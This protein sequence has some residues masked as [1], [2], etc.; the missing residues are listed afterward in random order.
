MR[1]AHVAVLVERLGDA[2]IGSLERDVV[3]L[4]ELKYSK[5]TS[6]PVRVVVAVA[7]DYDV[8][9]IHQVSEIMYSGKFA[10]GDIDLARRFMKAFLRGVRYH[11]DSLGP[12]GEFAGAQGDE[13]VYVVEGEGVIETQYGDLPFVQGDY[14]VIHRGILHRYRIA[15]P[16]RFVVFAS[17]GSVR[18]PR[19]YLN[20]YG[21]IVE[22][23]PDAERDIKGPRELKT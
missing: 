16:A 22:G 1:D 10:K 7:N 17:R 3:S 12:N 9:P 18:A 15:K 11:N 4:G 8:Y 19:R 5:A 20:D 13:V 14:V 21:Q 6:Q 2:L 23:A